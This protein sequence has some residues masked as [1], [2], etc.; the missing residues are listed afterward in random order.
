M[1]EA[2][3]IETWLRVRYSIIV[4]MSSCESVNSAA[5]TVPSKR[6]FEN[7]CLSAGSGAV[8]FAN[9]DCD[10]DVHVIHPYAR[11]TSTPT[12]WKQVRSLKRM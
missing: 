9:E 6:L 12:G 3:N 10:D 8:P 11:E 5:S 7:A 1:S 2:K 4:V